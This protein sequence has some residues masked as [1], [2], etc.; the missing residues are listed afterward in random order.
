[1]EMEKVP[2]A[3][4]AIEG[5]WITGIQR[6]VSFKNL[7]FP[8]KLISSLIKARSI[9]GAFKPHVAI[10]TGGFASGPLLQVAGWSGIPY[11]LQEQNSFAGI[12]NKIL[13]KAAERICVAYDGME[14]F[15]PSQKS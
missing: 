7:M 9:I 3:G 1:M 10:G 2:Q 12:T 8:F 15:F 5:L 6:K 14:K 4:Y 13:K 11:I